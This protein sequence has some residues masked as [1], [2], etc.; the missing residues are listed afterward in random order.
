[1]L[2]LLLSDLP[3]DDGWRAIDLSCALGG[4]G[5][6]LASLHGCSVEGVDPFKPAVLAARRL[7][8][9]QGLGGLCRFQVATVEKLPFEDQHFN[10]AVTAE[11]EAS[12]DE[13]RRVLTKDGVFAGSAAASDG[14]DSFRA[15][16]T[17]SG[18]SVEKLLDVTDY[19]LAFYRAKE[20]EARLLVEADLMSEADMLALQ[21]HTVDLYE[22]GD[23]SHVLFRA[24]IS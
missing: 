14:A 18:F 13:V 20:Q 19:A 24:R 10:L 8:K 5:R 2:R 12:W 16:L 15:S 11:G 22:A 23:A 6:W 9:A 17:G 1:M 7:A 4:N 3:I 21:M